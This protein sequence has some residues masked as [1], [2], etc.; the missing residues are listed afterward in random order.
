MA[1]QRRERL[2]VQ[3]WW[4]P[5]RSTAH[6]GQG[7]AL[8][9]A[10]HLHALGDRRSGHGA[11]EHRLRVLRARRSRAA[12]GPRPPRRAGARQR[13]QLR[14]QGRHA[15]RLPRRHLPRRHPPR[16]AGSAARLP[17]P[18][19]AE[20]W[21]GCAP[22]PA[23]P[24]RARWHSE[25]ALH[26]RGGAAGATSRRAAGARRSRSSGGVMGLGYG[27]GHALGAAAMTSARHS[28]SSGWFSA[29]LRLRQRPMAPMLQAARARGLSCAACARGGRRAS[30]A[31]GGE[32]WRRPASARSWRCCKPLSAQGLTAQALARRNAP[33]SQASEDRIGER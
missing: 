4:W 11:V 8:R 19:L 15:A 25:R 20:R 9:R 7:P 33:S 13:Q 29:R 17:L 14:R 24:T 2:K 18:D 10:G 12:S 3:H 6:C 22:R 30:A 1:R 5:A 28:A 32:R 21:R 26:L 16:C 23:V 27:L 31:E